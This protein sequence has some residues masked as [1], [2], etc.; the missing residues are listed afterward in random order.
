MKI[1]LLIIVLVIGT[2]TAAHAQRKKTQKHPPANPVSNAQA[3]WKPAAST[4]DYVVEFS[5][6]RLTRISPAVVRVW[7]RRHH[8][9]EK[10]DGFT[11]YLNE[12]N[13]RTRAFR[14][15]KTV[16]YD[17]SG[18]MLITELTIQLYETPNADWEFA[19]P[20]TLGEEELDH[21][22]RYRK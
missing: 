9:G 7:T 22:C 21:I 6:K 5:P 14:S 17:K 15:L 4:D 3:E 18:K 16:M 19:I 2:L 1:S 10:F 13:C 8:I 20:N 12:Y 11:M